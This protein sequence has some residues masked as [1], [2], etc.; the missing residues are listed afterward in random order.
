M[1]RVR[2]SGYKLGFQQQPAFPPP[3]HT[4]SKLLIVRQANELRRQQ[5]VGRALVA[6]L[7]NRIGASYAQIPRELLETQNVR[8]I[9]VYV[10][11][12]TLSKEEQQDEEE[13]PEDLP[14]RGA[15]PRKRRRSTMKSSRSGGEIGW[16]CFC[17]LCFYPCLCCLCS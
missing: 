16:P 11:Y 17:C 2:I 3:T 15:A 10:D 5:H 4:S 13:Q 14:R 7:Q 9:P 8:H 12:K 1:P 6:Q